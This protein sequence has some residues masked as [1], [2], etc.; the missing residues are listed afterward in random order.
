MI[1]FST[2]RMAFGLAFF[3][4]AGFY[5]CATTG[6]YMTFHPMEITEAPICSECH[7]DDRA[8]LDH[9][10]D[11][12]LRHK[13]LASQKMQLCSLCHQESFCSDCHAN[14]EEIKPSDKFKDMPQRFLPHRGDYLTQHRIDGR[15]NP[16]PC[17][18]CH[19]RN[20]NARCRACHK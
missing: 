6:S 17:L 13:F 9:T 11:Y 20:N 10:L 14:K 4:L 18:K 8:S 7:D 15:I 16:A 5:A 3:L 19:G 2:K 1:D 12:N